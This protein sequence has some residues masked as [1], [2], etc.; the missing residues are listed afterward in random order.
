[1]D[2]A[3]ALRADGWYLRSDIIW[4]KINCLPESVKDRPTK[5]YEHLFLFAKSSRYYYNAAAIMEP[6]AESSLKRY[7]RG[8][9][10]R[11]K[12]GRF[13][14]QGINGTDYNERMQGKTMRNKR[15]VWNI[16]TNSYRMGEH[17]AMFPEQL[18][19]PVFWQAVQK[20]VWFLIRSSEAELLV[21]LPSDCI[22]SVSELN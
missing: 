2:V 1:M 7:A 21:Q 22:G 19:E 4:N 10:G 16:S 6:A 15:D 18:V 17:F 13:S 11:N 12:Y 5:S 3:F 20:M 8:R 14:E 9:S